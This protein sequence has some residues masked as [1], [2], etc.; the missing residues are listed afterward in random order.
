MEP[1]Q[2]EALQGMKG[3]IS[4]LGHSQALGL[5][6]GLNAGHLGGSLDPPQAAGA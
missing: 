4:Q 6:L 2:V 3:Q 5:R 1:G